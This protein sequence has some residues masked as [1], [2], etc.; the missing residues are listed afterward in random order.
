MMSLAVYLTGGLFFVIAAA[1]TLAG[2]ANWERW[3]GLMML[4]VAA[5]A[6]LL[7][8]TA[9][10][11]YFNHDGYF[12]D[13]WTATE[14][15]NKSAGGLRSSVDYFS[16]IGPLYDWVLLAAARIDG[17]ADAGTVLV[18]CALA[19][20][21]ASVLA[22]LTLWGRISMLG[23]GVV[24]L[25][26]CAVALSGRGNGEILH[27]MP[28][29]YVAP[30]N[31]WGWSLFIPVV[32]SVL[33]PVT[34]LRTVS[35]VAIG[36]SIA[37]MLLLKVTYGAAALGLLAVQ[38]AITR[39]VWRDVGLSVSVAA[40]TLVVLEFATGQPSAHLADL[41][42][43]AAL[44]QSGLRIG[45]LFAQLGEAALYAV[46]AAVVYLVARPDWSGDG[47][48]RARAAFLRPLALML[49]AIGAGCA[50]L[51]QNHYPVEAAVYPAVVLAML[52]W[53]P[54]PAD[55]GLSAEAGSR[56]RILTAATAGLVLFYPI[57]DVGMHVG[58]R[59][60]Y[61]VNGI[62]PAFAGT[63]YAPVRF[64][65]Y[66]VGLE[67]SNLNTVSDGRAG[68]LEGWEMLREVGADREDTGSVA[69]FNFSNPFPM[70]LGKPSP[71]GT[72]IWL[73]EGRSF[74]PD[75]FVAADTFFDGVDYVLANR[76]GSSLEEIYAPTLARDFELAA[77]G[78]YWR[79][80]V[81]NP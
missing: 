17:T 63:P 18:A 12:G 27:K 37:L 74:S 54:R 43:T 71:A 80:F 75:I 44:P 57:V 58:Q 35:V 39:G 11:L 7:A 61:A 77:E 49:A 47:S 48:W 8:G 13:L 67:N 60:Q 28:M 62:D 34:R 52:E 65:P 9:P 30:Y 16:P 72:P 4:V 14:A 2:P 79:M 42:R 70:L 64:E 55:R 31:R 24:V 59:I 73:H 51:M 20:I 66:L 32:V 53:R 25:S 19:A 36:V 29:H 45:K 78:R 23:L 10:G 69:T 33:L 56:A 40:V 26:V 50:V 22:V 21:L 81:R 15:L 6:V 3:L 41:G 76:D 38:A 68:I 46:L 5:G 1:I